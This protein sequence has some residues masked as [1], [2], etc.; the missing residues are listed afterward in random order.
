MTSEGAI[1]QNDQAE[2]IVFGGIG[3]WRA[4]K[5][6]SFRVVLDTVIMHM[7]GVGPAVQCLA[8]GRLFTLMGTMLQSGIPLLEALSLC[9]TATGNRLLQRLFSRLEND[10]IN[11][12]GITPGLT[13][14]T[15]LPTGASQMIATA[16]RSGRLSDVM[17][18]VGEHYEEEGERQIRQ[19]VKFLEPAIIL[20]MGVF[21]SF[22]V[23]SVMLP[24]LDVNAGAGL[25]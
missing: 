24:L 21:V 7:K 17:Q 3:F 6:E 22:I 4:M 25:E 1:P 23:M 5:T 15:C 2:A 9:R 12:R 11:G 13:A 18:T 8:A 10:V 19:A 14:A 20:T 16:E